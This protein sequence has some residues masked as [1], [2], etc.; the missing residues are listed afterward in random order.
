[1]TDIVIPKSTIDTSRC[2]ECGEPAPVGDPYSGTVDDWVNKNI[3]WPLSAQ[4]C[5]VCFIMWSCMKKE[6]HN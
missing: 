2:C 1:M 5:C 6:Q 4:F 3:G